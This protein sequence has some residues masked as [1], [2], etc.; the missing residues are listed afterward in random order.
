M[1]CPGVLDWHL[2][3]ERVGEC[4]GSEAHGVLHVMGGGGRKS[5]ELSHLEGKYL[6][7]LD[8]MDNYNLYY[9]KNECMGTLG[10]KFGW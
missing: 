10:A 3:R 2:D 7:E 5:R 9:L 1:R 4:G 8:R 6:D